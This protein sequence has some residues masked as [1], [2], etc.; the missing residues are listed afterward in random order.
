MN[1][2]IFRAV[3]LA[4]VSLQFLVMVTALSPE[5]LSG[6]LPL[7]AQFDGYKVALEVVG[8][9]P[10]AELEPLQGGLPCVVAREGHDSA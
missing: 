6:G 10:L 1:R 2:R 3:F 7:S 4:W 9:V 8:D 5:P